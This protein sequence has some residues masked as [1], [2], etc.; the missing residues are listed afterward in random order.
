MPTDATVEPQME[1]A[2]H[3]QIHHENPGRGQHRHQQGIQQHEE[4]RQQ[5]Q[6]I[7]GAQ[8]TEPGAHHLVMHMIPVRKKQALAGTGPDKHHPD[9]IKTGH[10]ESTQG[11]HGLPSGP[12]VHIGRTVHENQHAVGQDITQAE[13]APIAHEQLEVPAATTV[14]IIIPERQHNAQ[15]GREQQQMQQM[16][17]L[18]AE[19]Q[20]NSQ[21]Q[22]AQAGSQT[23]NPVNQIHRIGYV[24]HKK[25]GQ[26]KAH[27][28]G[29]ISNT[30]QATQGIDSYPGQPEHHR[31]Q[32]LHQ[33]LPLVS[34]SH[35]IVHDTHNID[36]NQTSSKKGYPRK[37]LRIGRKV[38]R[39]LQ[40]QDN[41][42]HQGKTEEEY[43]YK[44][45]P[46]QTGRGHA[47]LLAGLGLIKQLFLI[48]KQ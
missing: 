1:Q 19:Q 18:H 4:Q 44:T 3:Q 10:H 6:Q 16:E 41:G 37:G 40:L 7:H 27:S 29:D 26:R 46:P 38:F 28:I 48:G 8:R 31:S 17:M 15:H 9:N 21:S 32:D 30:E 34:Q 25:N 14:D 12:R 33:K 11:Y 43:G 13:T 45:N 2:P 39:R 5:H 47:M 23:V 20:E 36:Q 42:A 22:N 24:D 35:Q